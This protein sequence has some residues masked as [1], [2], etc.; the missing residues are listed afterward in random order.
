MTDLQQA[1]AAAAE[2]P[3]VNDNAVQS[4]ALWFDVLRE[5]QAAARRMHPLRIGELFDDVA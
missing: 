1:F 5:Y 4:W 2:Q 3:A